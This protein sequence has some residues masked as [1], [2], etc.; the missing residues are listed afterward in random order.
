MSQAAKPTGFFGKL[1]AR[2]MA[3]GHRGFYENTAKVLNLTPDDAYLEIGFGSGLFIK[4]YASR[5]KRIAGLDYSEDM[6]KLASNI[7]EGI[8]KSGKAEFKQ[9]DV[10]TLPW[11]ENEFSAVAGIETFYFWPKPQSSLKEILRVLIPGGRLVLEMAYNKD[12]GKDHTKQVEKHNLKLYSGEEMKTLLEESGFSEI[13]IVY[14]KSLWIPF[15][16]YIVPK[17][18][19]AKATKSK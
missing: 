17:G 5:V 11:N 7:N 13:S 15:K 10:S 18:M 19:I 4:K 6:V 14:Y 2:G 16:G 9:G 8:V 1:S 3:L 12:D